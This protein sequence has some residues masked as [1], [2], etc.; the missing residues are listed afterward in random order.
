[1][2]GLVVGRAAVCGFAAWGG[3]GRAGGVEVG[4]WVVRAVV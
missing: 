2:C 1:M 3:E 4:V